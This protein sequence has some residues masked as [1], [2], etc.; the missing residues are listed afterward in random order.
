MSNADQVSEHYLGDQGSNYVA[1]RL[2]D[3]SSR[4]YAINA[5]YF[6][7]YISSQTRV[8]DFGCGNG[9]M[10]L[11]LRP[12][13]R[14]MV[15]LEVSESARALAVQTGVK[16]YEGL[17]FLPE[18][19]RFDVII[20]NSVLEH[21]PNVIDVMKSL[22]EHLTPGGLFV[23]KLPIDD[24]RNPHQRGWSK[25]DVDCHL[26]TWTPRLFANVLYESGYEVQDIRIICSAW[27][28]RLF[29]L[30]KVGLDRLAFWAMA[31][32][33]HRRQLFAVARR[34]LK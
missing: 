16:I 31:Y 26:H 1:Q 15:G 32:F 2:A 10:I 13:V 25:D 22:K 4:G 8:L 9:G 5:E 14:E 18:S 34:P 11:H 19:E 28:P 33:K 29:P 20:S 3:P 6:K 23:T 17:D 24:I 27:S 21:I 7:P 30:A 12:H